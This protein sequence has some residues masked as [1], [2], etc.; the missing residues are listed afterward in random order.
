MKEKIFKLGSSDT[1]AFVKLE[2]EDKYSIRF[3]SNHFFEEVWKNS[4]L[5]VYAFTQ[6]A[7]DEFVGDRKPIFLTELFLYQNE[8]T[9][10]GLR[11]SV[12]VQKI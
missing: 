4:N 1:L 3:M 11:I 10:M 7:F 6:K 9:Q 2:E 5:I 12:E 8:L